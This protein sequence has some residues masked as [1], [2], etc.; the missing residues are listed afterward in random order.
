MSTSSPGLSMRRKRVEQRLLGAIGNHDIFRLIRKRVIAQKFFANFF[1]Q[2]QRTG[3]GSIARHAL[4]N[5]VLRGGANVFRR[6]EIRLARA[7]PNHIFPFRAQLFGLCVDRKSN[8]W[9]NR[10]HAL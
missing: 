6:G 1:A 10:R 9:R 8:R 7:K 3:H 2:G 5:G 4:V